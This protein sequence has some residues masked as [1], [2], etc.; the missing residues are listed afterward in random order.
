MVGIAIERRRI[1]IGCWY[2]PSVGYGRSNKDEMH[3][4]GKQRRVGSLDASWLLW[5]PEGIVLT[6]R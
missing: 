4:I 5:M 2:L 6:P 3:C 1:D